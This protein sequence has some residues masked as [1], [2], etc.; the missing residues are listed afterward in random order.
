MM[1]KAVQHSSTGTAGT[2]PAA[3]MP[4]SMID[5]TAPSALLD[6]LLQAQ[7][8]QWDAMLAWQHSIAEWQQDLWD[9]W[10]SHWGGGV[11]I[12]A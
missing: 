9:Q 3:Q 5:F 8:Q 1:V 2:S 11:P 10:V 12:D 4:P 6:T 7:R